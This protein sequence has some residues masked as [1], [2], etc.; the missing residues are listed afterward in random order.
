ML[1]TPPCRRKATAR[2]VEQGGADL[3]ECVQ[4]SMELSTAGGVSGGV[5]LWLFHGSLVV[6]H[7]C[8]TYYIYKM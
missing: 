5:F 3:S 4:L 7:A 1:S 6:H 2:A 8:D